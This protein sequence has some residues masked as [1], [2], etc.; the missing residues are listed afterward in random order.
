[1]KTNRRNAGK[2]QICT[3]IKA[4]RDCDINRRLISGDSALSVANDNGLGVRPMRKH[5]GYGEDAEGNPNKPHFSQQVKT[6]MAIKDTAVGLDLLACQKEVYDLSIEAAKIA[7]GKI[8]SKNEDVKPDLRSFGSCISGAAK[9]VEV[10]AKVDPA[11]N[12]GDAPKESAFW[13]AY[14]ERAKVVFNGQ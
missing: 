3:Y 10:L 14:G 2:C 6:A 11:K 13:L 8:A 7:M 1:M 12:L 4:H 9:V 5:A